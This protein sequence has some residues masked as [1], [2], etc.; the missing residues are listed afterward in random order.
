MRTDPGGSRGLDDYFRRDY[1]RNI[2]AEIMGRNKFGPQRGPWHDHD[3]RGWWGEEPP[4][5]TPVFV[6]T[7]HTRPSFTLGDTTFHF[8]DPVLRR[9]SIGRGTRRRARTSDLAAGPPPSGSFSTPAS[10]TRCTWRSRRWSSDPGRDSGNHPMP[11][12]HSA[13]KWQHGIRV[14]GAHDR[15]EP[16][17]LRAIMPATRRT[18]NHPYSAGDLHCYSRSG[19]YLRMQAQSIMSAITA[20]DRPHTSPL[21]RFSLLGTGRG[22]LRARRWSFRYRPWCGGS[23][24]AC[25]SCRSGRPRQ[26]S[27]D[28]AAPVPA[29]R[30][31]IV[32]RGAA[33]SK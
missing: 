13:G 26:A 23:C 22:S 6:L 7:H 14:R 8:V 1:A 33:L 20:D 31:M 3:W 5:H 24:Q 19:T 32:A 11:G 4:F 12:R 2:G 28:D 27:P 21:A 15:A 17:D 9:S 10:S 25:R 16:D 29:P 18:V 30:T